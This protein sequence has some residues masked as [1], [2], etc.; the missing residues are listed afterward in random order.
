MIIA[1]L[2]ISEQWILNFRYVEWFLCVFSYFQTV[3]L[4]VLP[5]HDRWIK[6]IFRCFITVTLKIFSNWWMIWVLA[7]FPQLWW[8]IL[9][10]FVTIS[11]EWVWRSYLKVRF[12]LGIPSCLLVLCLSHP[13]K[14]THWCYLLDFSGYFVYR[15]KIKSNVFSRPK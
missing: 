11:E 13:L 12:N 10:A 1:C 4:K 7:Y 6:C 15:P 14:F 2:T 5:N 8:M 3:D 9:S